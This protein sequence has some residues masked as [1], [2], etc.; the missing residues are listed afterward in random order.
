MFLCPAEKQL[1]QTVCQYVADVRNE[2]GESVANTYFWQR[3]RTVV[4][5][6]YLINQKTIW[7]GERIYGRYPIHRYVGQPRCGQLFK[8]ATDNL[9]NLIEAQ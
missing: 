1:P 2:C 9:A 6:R 4:D 7:E 3:C 5:S 8:I